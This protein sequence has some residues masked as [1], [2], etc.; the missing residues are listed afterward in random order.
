MSQPYSSHQL[1]L[2]ALIRMAQ[3]LQINIPKTIVI[4]GLEIE[5]NDDFGEGLSPIVTLALPHFLAVIEK[6]L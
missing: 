2:P 5:K 1:S 3:L 6:E 4:Y